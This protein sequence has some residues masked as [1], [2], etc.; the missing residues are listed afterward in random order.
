[1]I[2]MLSGLAVPVLGRLARLFSNKDGVSAYRIVLAATL[3]AV[4]WGLWAGWV[5]WVVLGEGLSGGFG[6][7]VGTF[8]ARWALASWLIIVLLWTLVGDDQDDL[9]GGGIGVPL[10]VCLIGTVV[11]AMVVHGAFEP[12]PPPTHYYVTVSCSHCDAKCHA[13]VKIGESWTDWDSVGCCKCGI[14]VPPERVPEYATT[15]EAWDARLLEDCS[16]GE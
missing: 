1:V 15:R 10:A 7:G 6:V 13:H 14:L 8:L 9:C 4:G 5:Q 12:S 2:R 3:A 11:Q 16:D